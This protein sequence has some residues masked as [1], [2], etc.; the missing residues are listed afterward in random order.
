MRSTCLNAS[1]APPQR[2]TCEN[3]PVAISIDGRFRKR[4]S[5]G[6]VIQPG[7]RVKSGSSG[8]AHS[9]C[10]VV[11]EICRRTSRAFSASEAVVGY[12]AYRR[13]RLVPLPKPSNDRLRIFIGNQSPTRGRPFTE[14]RWF[15]VANTS[16]T[17]VANRLLYVNPPARRQ[18]RCKSVEGR[19]N[20]VQRRVPVRVTFGVQS[21]S[22]APSYANLLR[23][24]EAAARF[25]ESA[26]GVVG[27][28]SPYATLS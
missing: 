21:R 22:H 1:L 28:G 9:P 15:H 3:T 19:L 6:P 25:K 8:T 17:H 2:S 12:V 20:V 18:A 7:K 4:R 11:H 24:T 10:S 26:A 27:G 16:S 13:I 14:Y 23:R 5:A